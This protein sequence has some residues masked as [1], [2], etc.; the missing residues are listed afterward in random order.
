M[1]TEEISNLEREMEVLKVNTTR[2]DSIIDIFEPTVGVSQIASKISS[3]YKACD[4]LKKREIIKTVFTN[5]LLS[6]KPT[7]SEAKTFIFYSKET[8]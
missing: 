8:V 2:K 6:G 1:F 3:I 4:K 7:V 5:F